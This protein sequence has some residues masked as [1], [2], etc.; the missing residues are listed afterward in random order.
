MSEPKS[1][2]DAFGWLALVVVAGAIIWLLVNRKPSAGDLIP[3][4]AEPISVRDMEVSGS[5][6]AAVAMLMFSDFECPYCG[7]FAR[8]SL[9]AIR[10][11]YVETGKVLLAFG[12]FPLEKLH[13]S[14]LKA[15]MAAECAATDGKFWEMHDGLFRNQGQ[16]GETLFQHEAETMRVEIARFTACLVSAPATRIGR[17]S[18]TAR[19]LGITGTPAFLFGR[20]NPDGRV[21]VV[22]T[23]SGAWPVDFYRSALDRL[24]AKAP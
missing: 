18:Q 8:E 21:S 24:L 20:V 13:P 9:P 12:H 4:P 6:H 22:Q 16:L 11:D 5:G 19:K 2:S 7:V 23:L 15:A 17:A 14:A 1:R 10:R 3:V